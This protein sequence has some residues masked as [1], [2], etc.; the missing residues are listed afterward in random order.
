VAFEDIDVSGKGCISKEDLHILFKLRCG[1]DISNTCM[2]TIFPILDRNNDGKICKQDFD[3]WFAKMQPLLKNQITLSLHQQH[4][5]DEKFNQSVDVRT[6]KIPVVPSKRQIPCSDMDKTFH[7]QDDKIQSVSSSNL[8]P[9]KWRQNSMNENENF[10]RDDVVISTS[11]IIGDNDITANVVKNQPLP[12]EISSFIDIAGT[13]N[14]EGSESSSSDATSGDVSDSNNR[15]SGD[16]IDDFKFENAGNMIHVMG[17]FKN[18]DFMDDLVLNYMRKIS[19][20]D[21]ELSNDF[22]HGACI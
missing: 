20:S 5:N 13:V 6:S 12:L 8:S 2:D 16:S 18:D 17:L 22:S 7:S 10:S 1:H 11:N 14:I 3:S 15:L 4:A 9:R 21:K 19:A